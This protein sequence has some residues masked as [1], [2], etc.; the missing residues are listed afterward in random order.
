MKHQPMDFW[1]CCKYRQVFGRQDDNIKQCYIRSLLTE[2]FHPYL[3]Y[4]EYLK[5]LLTWGTHPVETDRV[6]SSNDNITRDPESS[7]GFTKFDPIKSSAACDWFWET[8]PQLPTEPKDP[9]LTDGAAD[10]KDAVEAVV[11][12]LSG[13]TDDGDAVG[14]DGLFWFAKNVGVRI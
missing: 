4:S 5:K 14:V 6:I 12:V 3:N 11:P 8:A 13:E 1:S 7:I 10:E 2:I 9:E